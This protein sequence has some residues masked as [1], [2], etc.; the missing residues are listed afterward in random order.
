[1]NDHNNT[2]PRGAVDELTGLLRQPRPAA[3]ELLRAVG[4]LQ[5]RRARVAQEP[6]LA[7]EVSRQ[8]EAARP[9]LTAEAVEQALGSLPPGLLGL[10]S[11][12]R[13]LL[14]SATPAEATLDQVTLQQLLQRRERLEAVIWG[15]RWAVGEPPLAALAQQV[16]RVDRLGRAAVSSFL[17]CNPARRAAADELDPA[18]AAASWWWTLR[19][20]CDPLGLVQL[21]DDALDGARREAVLEHLRTCGSCQED[22]RWLGRVEG[23]LGPVTEGHVASAELTAFAAGEL[24]AARREAIATHLAECEGCRQLQWAAAAGLEEAE[25]VERSLAALEAVAAQEEEALPVV[26][27]PFAI[28]PPARAVALAADTATA[29]APLPRDRRVL[30]EEPGRFRLVYYHVDGQ[31]RA[32]LFCDDPAAEV[33]LEADLDGEPLVP[34]RDPEGALTLDLGPAGRL[35]GRTLAVRLGL[36]G[37]AR[38]LSWTFVEEEGGG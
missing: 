32:G 5:R 3:L 21:L 16:E 29:A 17:V 35:P 23:L 1:M 31:G 36:A 8:L 4:A 2:G 9:H 33:T 11:R 10:A 15:A 19:A 34:A 6:G 24:P 25:K 7:A 20:R 22:A 26:H 37:A 38:R 14:E 27:L 18:A 13:E 12:L 30:L 28:A